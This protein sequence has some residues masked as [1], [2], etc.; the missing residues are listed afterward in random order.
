MI[1]IISK[2]LKNRSDCDT[3]LLGIYYFAFHKERRYV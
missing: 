3:H 1:V 2:K